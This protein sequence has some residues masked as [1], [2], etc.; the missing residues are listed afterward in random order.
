MRTKRKYKK[1]KKYIKT[2]KH[3][4]KQSKFTI[5]RNMILYYIKSD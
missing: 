2:K 4:K 1:T 3:K 5:Y